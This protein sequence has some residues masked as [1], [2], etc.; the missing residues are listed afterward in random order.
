MVASGFTVHP[1]SSRIPL[2]SEVVQ[3]YGVI[4]P[5]RMLT[6]WSECREVFFHNL[7]PVPLNPFC[8]P[9]VDPSFLVADNRVDNAD[10][11]EDFVFGHDCV[12][13]DSEWAQFC[14]DIL[15]L[16]Q[17]IA[18]TYDAVIEMVDDMIE[19]LVHAV[20]GGERFTY[21][22]GS[23]GPRLMEFVVSLVRFLMLCGGSGVLPRDY[24]LARF[25][26]VCP[27][28]A[29]GPFAYRGGRSMAHKM[30]R[31]LISL[32]RCVRGLIRAAWDGA[33][34][35]DPKLAG[36]LG[37]DAGAGDFSC[38]LS[39]VWRAA[40]GS[41]SA[42]ARIMQNIIGPAYDGKS[43]WEDG[44][45][46]H[47][48]L[49]SSWQPPFRLSPMSSETI[50]GAVLPMLVYGSGVYSR[51]GGVDRQ[52]QMFLLDLHWGFMHDA[53]YAFMC[54]DQVPP[55]ELLAVFGVVVGGG[56]RSASREFR[57]EGVGSWM[58]G[59]EGNGLSQFGDVVDAEVM[60][61]FLAP[62]PRGKLFHHTL[63]LARAARYDAHHQT[64]L[65]PKDVVDQRS[66]TGNG[67][68]DDNVLALVSAVSADESCL[69]RFEEL[70][71]G[72]EEGVLRH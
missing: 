21:G 35:F 70:G 26:D 50:S 16:E 10:A 19:T 1:R 37:L 42:F 64:V 14:R 60:D 71:S 13:T 67:F 49:T 29:H 58:V 3:L 59:G 36:V 57:V 4:S 27:L 28:A 46:I 66:W 40:M 51:Y 61:W 25:G 47:E 7:E 15:L 20:C 44:H 23:E 34:W 52:Y 55:R 5:G 53:K 38:R 62:V 33:V 63:A 22:V 32:G 17:P 12:M 45:V 72:E 56:G 2:L 48:Y 11:V 30:M 6:G 54:G 8:S 39:S 9:M 69:S 24:A 31:R 68:H 65:A 43:E 18:Q 41:E